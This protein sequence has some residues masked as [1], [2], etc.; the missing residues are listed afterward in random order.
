MDQAVERWLLAVE[1]RVQYRVTSYWN[2]ELAEISA[3]H[4]KKQCTKCDI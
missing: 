4:R 1:A 2:L 3:C